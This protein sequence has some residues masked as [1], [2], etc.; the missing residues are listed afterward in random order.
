[1]WPRGGRDRNGMM[2]NPR[3][4][5]WSEAD[6]LATIASDALKRRSVEAY[7]D[8]VNVMNE[9]LAKIQELAGLRE[10]AQ[11]CSLSDP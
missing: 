10:D 6:I 4:P 11:V 5:R 8:A 7:L 9:E 2:H 3:D 1:M